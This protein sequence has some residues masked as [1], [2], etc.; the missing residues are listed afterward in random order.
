MA[1][2]AVGLGAV[3]GLTYLGNKILSNDENTNLMNENSEY[4]DIINRLGYNGGSRKFKE[5]KNIIGTKGRSRKHVK[6]KRKT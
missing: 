2:I 5:L 4:T 6:S 1:A 3:L